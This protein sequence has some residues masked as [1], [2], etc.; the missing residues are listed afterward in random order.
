MVS[1]MVMLF[2]FGAD[3]DAA[4]VQTTGGTVALA[5]DGHTLKLNFGHATDWPGIVLRAPQGHWDL[6]KYA[7]LALEV[8][9][10]GPAKASLCCRVD[11]PG[12][13][14]VK[15]CNTATLELEA[16]ASGT[17]TV[18]FNRRSAALAG[19]TLFGMQIGR[20]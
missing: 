12:A 4:K 10:V 16:G 19:I 6:D 15:N 2:A 9:N 8:K 14:G 7:E 17:L 11:N 1:L 13:D 18:H 20:A 5:G 3:F